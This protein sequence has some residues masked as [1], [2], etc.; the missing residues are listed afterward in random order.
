MRNRK[1]QIIYGV[2]L[3]AALGLNLYLTLQPPA[4][5]VRLS[6]GLRLWLKQFGIYSDFQSFRS[7]AHLAVYF[8]VGILLTLF[9]RECGWKWWLIL[10]MGAALGLVDEGVKYFL[11]TREFEV[12]DL[13]RDCIGVAVAILVIWLSKKVYLRQLKK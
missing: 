6:E 9:G 4:Q 5:T 3:L 8:V 7:N 1:K 13:V 10:L 12:V 11:P 2:L